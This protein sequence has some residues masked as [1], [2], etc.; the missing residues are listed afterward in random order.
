MIE[1]HHFFVFL[2]AGLLLNITPGPDMTYVATRSSTQGKMAGLVSSLG[3]GTGALFH[4]SAAAVGVSAIIFYSSIG[5]QVVKWA[6]ALYLIYLGLQA[7]LDSRRNNDPAGSPAFSGPDNLLAIYRKGIL[8][9]LLNP[10][11]ALFFMAFLPQFVDP[12][13]QYFPFNIILLGLIFTACGTVVNIIV[14]YFFGALGEWISGSSWFHIV[15]SW[16]SGLVYFLLGLGLAVT[17]K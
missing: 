11:V 16:F 15:K 12:G 14:A 5:F 1:I 10:K 9:N 17:K 2:S 7:I 4:I 3:V 6:G 13:A 8:V